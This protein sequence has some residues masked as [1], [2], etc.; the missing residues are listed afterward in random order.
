[1][2]LPRRVRLVEVGLR[3]GLQ[4][5]PTFV[6]TAVKLALAGLLAEAGHT[7]IEL[8]SFVSPKWV[9]Q[10]RDASDLLGSLPRVAGVS[11]PVLVPN[12]QGL[13]RALAAGTREIAVFVSASEA[14]SKKN[15]NCTIAESVKRTGEVTGRA[16][17]AGLSVRGY[18]SCA[19]ACPYQGPIAPQ[20]VAEVA[21]QLFDLGC[22]EVSLGD[23]IGVA[24]PEQVKLLLEACAKIADLSRFA[25]H[26][27]DT[28]GMAI[29]NVYASLTMGLT[30]FDCSVAGLGGCPYA[31]GAAGNVASEDLVYL[32][33]GLGIDCGVD[34]QGLLTAASFILDH[35]GR[36][37]QSKVGRA[38]RA[39]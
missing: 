31:P 13:E 30:V 20:E 34:L 21:G 19:V 38:K 18:L 16:L 3:D 10:M 6:P 24:T 33:N 36:P 8:T 7:I 4:N 12:L 5:E 27:H 28:Y 35:L 29:A 39:S 25:G 1:M 14:F 23:T 17:A 37:A 22:A 11:Y 32:L 9:E 26:F 15:T 2:S